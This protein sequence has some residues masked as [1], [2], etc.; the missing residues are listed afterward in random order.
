MPAAFEPTAFKLAAFEPAAFEAAASEACLN[1]VARYDAQNPAALKR[2][3][4]HGVDLRP[5]SHDVLT[6]SRDQHSRH[7]FWPSGFLRPG[8]SRPGG[9][10]LGYEST[11]GGANGRLHP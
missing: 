4:D 7:S 1:M 8:F 3:L 5:F 2:L 11:M 10:S 6:A 9:L